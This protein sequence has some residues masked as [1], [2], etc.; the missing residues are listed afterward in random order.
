[1]NIIVSESAK[2]NLLKQT[3]NQ[4]KAAVRI[5]LQGFG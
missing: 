4:D 5:L 2:N 1:L 3:K